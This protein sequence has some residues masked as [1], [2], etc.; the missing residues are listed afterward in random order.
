MAQD[1]SKPDFWETRYRTEVTPWDAGGTPARFRRYIEG[2]PKESRILIPGCGSGYEV[3]VC[4]EAGMDVLAI[5]FSP[6][7]VESAQ[8]NLGS[9]ADRVVLADFFEFAF[10]TAF[11]VMYERAFLCALPRR[12]WSSYAKR[13]SQLLKPGGAIAGFWFFDDNERGPP[14]GTSE[15]ELHELLGQSFERLSDESVE[16][17]IPMFQGKERWQEWR[18]TKTNRES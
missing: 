15:R 5:D 16:E 12:M 7:A 18:V 8:K 17:S 13:T 6:A 9:L 11:D 2:L 3:A 14:F 1:S 10:D 4:S